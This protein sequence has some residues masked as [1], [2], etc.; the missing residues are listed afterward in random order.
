MLPYASIP[1]AAAALG[2]NLT[3][4]ETLWFNYSAAKSNYFLYCHNIL[5]LFLFLV[6]SLVPL[7]LVFL[8]FKRFSFVSS[9]KIQPKV[10]LSLT[11]TFKCYKDIMHMF[12][13]VVGPFQLISY[14]SIQVRSPHQDYTNYWIHR[15]LHNDWGYEKIHRVHHEYHAPIGFVAPYAHW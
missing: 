1:E 6:F 5:F 15:F 3:F 4:A 2:R 13:L 7:P 9:H 14:P 8:E 12:F 11:E 10:H